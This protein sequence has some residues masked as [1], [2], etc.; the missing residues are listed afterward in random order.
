VASD[1][2]TEIGN[3]RVDPRVS[4]EGASLPPTD[5]ADQHSLGDLS[6]RHHEQW[7]TAVA[8]A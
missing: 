2:I 8:L 3:A 4:R 1:P 6:S 5:N 7:T